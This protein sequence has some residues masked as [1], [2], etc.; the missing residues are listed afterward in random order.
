MPDYTF[1]KYDDAGEASYLE[2]S[3][4]KNLAHA[5]AWA[6]HMFPCQAVNIAEVVHWADEPKTA[7]CNEPGCCKP[8]PQAEWDCYEGFCANCYFKGVMYD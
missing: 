5:K 3:N 4:H 7:S 8:I 6:S 1:W 2:T